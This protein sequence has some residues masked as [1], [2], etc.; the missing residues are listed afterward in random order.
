M[1]TIAI[2]STNKIP[3]TEAM[4]I[5]VKLEVFESKFDVETE[6]EFKFSD[7]KLSTLVVM[8]TGAT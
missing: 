2:K 6:L 3:A 8:N 5:I 1:T 7:E 4:M